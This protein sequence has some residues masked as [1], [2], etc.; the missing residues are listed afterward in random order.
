MANPKSLVFQMHKYWEVVESL[1]QASRELPAFADSH[2]LNIISPITTHR[3][4]QMSKVR[5][6]A[7]CVMPI[8]C[9]SLAVPT[10]CS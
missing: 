10:V 9:C 5:F 8:C 2:V 3:Q 6:C 7:P 1:A 4:R